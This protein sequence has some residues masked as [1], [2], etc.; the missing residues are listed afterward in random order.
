MNHA[1][2]DPRMTPPPRQGLLALSLQEA[3]T[4]TVRLRE[5]RQVATDSFSF[6]AHLKQLLQGA[7]QEGR[8]AGYPVE[9]VRQAIYAFVA[10][11]DESVLNSP[12]PAFAEWSRQPLQEELFGDHIAGENFFRHLQQLLTQ[13]DS[14]DLAD[15]L[16]VYQLCLLLGF[17]GRHAMGDRG[18][19]AQLARQT[20]ER[21]ARIRGPEGGMTPWAA[22]PPGEEA[23]RVRDPWVRR[24]ILT[25]GGL[26]VVVIVLLPLF[27]F[28]LGAG[29]DP[30]RAMGN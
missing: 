27:R 22:L 10:F 4:V 19:L 13:P 28:L 12:L 24:L 15:L 26:L 1:P 18:E 20:G 3:F 25:G 30:L 7:E 21:I 11:L 16:E 9:Q 29:L 5:G 23:P 8:Q 14:P 17:K 2:P 6:R